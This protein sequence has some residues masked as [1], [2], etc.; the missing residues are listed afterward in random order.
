ML[1]SINKILEQN[2]LYLAIIFSLLVLVLSLINV[3]NV[4][5]FNFNY[6][7]KIEHI[8]AYTV[9][10][11]FWLLSCKVGKVKLKYLN[12]LLLIIAYGIIIE[13]LQTSVTKHRTGDLLDVMANSIGVLLGY[14]FLKILSRINL[15]V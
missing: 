8:I 5:N 13:V 7:D 6:T 9:I 2:S 11:Y 1:K 12:L 15:Q 3:E 4:P 10:S 14:V